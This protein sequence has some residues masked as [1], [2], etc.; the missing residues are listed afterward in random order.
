M[1]KMKSLHDQAVELISDMGWSGM[2]EHDAAEVLANARFSVS[3][4]LDLTEVVDDAEL[5]RGRHVAYK[6]RNFRFINRTRAAQ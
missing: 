3:S 6:A 5:H 2:T 1:S 4:I